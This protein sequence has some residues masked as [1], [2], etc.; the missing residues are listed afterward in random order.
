M[1][2]PNIL[3]SVFKPFRNCLFK[4]K[5][6]DAY[7]LETD[8]TKHHCKYVIYNCIFN[9]LTNGCNITPAS[10]STPSR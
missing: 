7:D 1:L 10:N 2:L 8:F 6:C 9:K 4:L 5:L 3:T